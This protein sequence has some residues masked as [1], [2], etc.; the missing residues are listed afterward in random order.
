MDGWVDGWSSCSC[1]F[2]DYNIQTVSLRSCSGFC[3]ELEEEFCILSSEFI[4]H[5]SNWQNKLKGFTGQLS[6]LKHCILRFSTNFCC[7]V[8]KSHIYFIILNKP[9][10][11]YLNKK[12]IP[13]K[14]VTSC[15]KIFTKFI[16]IFTVVQFHVIK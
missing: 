16:A 2:V 7:E 12:I 5:V 8:G 13:E 6:V 9:R 4:Y 15:V 1:P 3:E 14:Q 10:L 11:N